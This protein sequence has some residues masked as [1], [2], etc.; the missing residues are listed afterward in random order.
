MEFHLYPS[1]PRILAGL[2]LLVALFSPTLPT[3]A[4]GE[5]PPGPVYI[6]KEGD[7]LWD[8][9]VK[10]GVSVEELK[11]YNQITN[12]DLVGVGSELVIPGLEGIEGVVD[13]QSIP[14][15]ENLRSLSRRYGVG[16][17]DLRRLNR[18]VSPAQLYAGMSLILPHSNTASLAGRRL[19]LSPGQSLLELAVIQGTNPWRLI[20]TN[21]LSGTWEALPG[22]VLHLPDANAADGPGGLPGAIGALQVEPLPLVQGKTTVIRLTAD[23]E[24]TAAGSLI[25]HELHFFKEAA[26]GYVALQGV[27]ALTEP[28]LYPLTL[29]GALADGA[30]FAFSQRVFVKKGGYAYDATLVVDPATIDPANTEPENELW[31]ALPVEA[32]P[33]KWWEGQWVYPAS[34]LFAN[35]YPSYFGSRRSYN[36]GPYNYFHTGLDICGGVGAEVYAPAPGTVVYTGTLTV[37]GNAIMLNHGWGIYTGYEHLSEILVKVGDRVESG[38]LIS[39]VGGSGRVTG[40]HLHWEIWAGGVQVEPLDWLERVF[41]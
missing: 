36:G 1:Y 18:L 38:Q 2:F 6:V 10:F 29:R 33:E 3:A 24:L 4:Q 17:D 7:T 35:C 34:A 27:H 12:A 22:D 32:T 21:T 26:G 37:R 31:N 28:G 30:P 19:A 23:G 13:A 25:G 5:K 14:F 9:A 39:R 16:M 11:A 40:A 15:G 20:S 8:I 41:P